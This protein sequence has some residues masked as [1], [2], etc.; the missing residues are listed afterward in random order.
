MYTACPFP[1]LVLL[2][3]AMPSQMPQPA[4][5]TETRSKT[6]RKEH[7]EAG[8]PKITSLKN[9]I[10]HAARKWLNFTHNTQ[11]ISILRNLSQGRL[12]PKYY[13][14]VSSKDFKWN[15]EPSSSLSHT[16]TDFVW[17]I[18]M[19]LKF[20]PPITYAFRSFVCRYNFGEKNNWKFGISCLTKAGKKTWDTKHLNTSGWAR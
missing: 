14:K 6:R 11:R 7:E 19:T 2:Q 5:F 12:S 16:K 17:N 4:S 15:A 8:R 18:N 13:S 20:M 9:L 3:C 1:F 10:L